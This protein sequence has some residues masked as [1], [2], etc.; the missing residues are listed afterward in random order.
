M[1]ATP[2][3]RVYRRLAAV[4]AVAEG[5]PLVAVA[6]QARVDR[7]TVRRWVDRYLAAHD[8]NALADDDRSGRPALRALTDRRLRRVLATDPRT[9]GYHAATWTA[10]LLAS[11]CAERF[12]CVVS[13]RTLRRRL[14]ALGYRW[15]RPRYR[16]AHRATHLAQKKGLSAVA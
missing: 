12:N 10:P 5:Q 11:Y 2:L 9:R 16:Y 1:A 6:R 13:A 7:T 3:A 8:P 4:L 15:K 14:H